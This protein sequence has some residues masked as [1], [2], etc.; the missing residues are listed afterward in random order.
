M[1]RE[2]QAEESE[3]QL[4]NQ[5]GQDPGIDTLIGGEHLESDNDFWDICCNFGIIEIKVHTHTCMLVFVITSY[6]L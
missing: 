4:Q 2:L 3:W 6:T 1:E 5:G